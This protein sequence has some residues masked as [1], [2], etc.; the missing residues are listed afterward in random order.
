LNKHIEFWF[1]EDEIN[2]EVTLIALPLQ[3]FPS[4]VISYGWWHATGA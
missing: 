1:P 2:Y 4:A 3:G